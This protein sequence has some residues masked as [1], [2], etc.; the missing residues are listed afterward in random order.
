MSLGSE[1]TGENRIVLGVL[2]DDKNRWRLGNVRARLR[3]PR[4]KGFNFRVGI[5][6]SLP[7]MVFFEERETGFL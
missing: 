7:D 6:I 5:R 4:N 1:G 3:K 2:C